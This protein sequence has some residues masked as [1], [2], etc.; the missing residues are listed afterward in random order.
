M[1]Y[2]HD[3]PKNDEMVRG[4]YAKSFGPT[5]LGSAGKSAAFADEKDALP[6]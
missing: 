2:L 4:Y 6:P 3:L 5:R 1:F